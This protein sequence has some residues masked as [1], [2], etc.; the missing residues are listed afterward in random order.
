MQDIAASGE[1]AHLTQER[2]WQETQR[3]LGESQPWVYFQALKDCNALAIIF[4]ELDNLFGIPQPEKH[5]PEI[6][7]GIHSLMVLEQASKL[8]EDSQIRWASLLHDL[9]KGLTKD[10]LLPSHHGHEQTGEQLVIELNQR[11]KTPNEFKDLSRLVCLYHTHVH[12]AFELKP[13]TLLKFFNKIDLWRKPERLQQILLA[14]KADSR[15]RTG[16]EDIE[17]KQMEY[18][19]E[20]AQACLA[21]NAKQFVV[22]GIK[23]KAIGEAIANGRLN[24]IKK[25]SQK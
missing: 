19:S 11:L 7:C 14:C 12:R 2:V 13:Q 17:Y 5:H 25:L 1:L 8:S 16:F 20:I 4:P 15:G 23:G 24:I 21:I 9:G 6:D 3:A 10:E 22:Q 18:I